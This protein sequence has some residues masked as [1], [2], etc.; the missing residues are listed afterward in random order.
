MRRNKNV[1]SAQCEV[2]WRSLRNCCSVSPARLICERR[3]NG[4][5][6]RCKGI[7]RRGKPVFLSVTWL[8]SGV[9][10]A[11]PARTN[12]RP[13]CA[14]KSR[15][16]VSH[17]DLNL[18]GEHFGKRSDFFLARSLEVG[19][20]SLA[21]ILQCRFDRLALRHAT[22]ELRHIRDVAMVFRVEDQVNK[23]PPGLSH[24]RI[25]EPRGRHE[26]IFVTS[27]NAHPRSRLRRGTGGSQRSL[28]AN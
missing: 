24:A 13:P 10:A 22:G 19:D 16:G 18:A 2:S 27:W 28:A 15:P 17:A 4:E 1:A 7:T 5:T 23:K 11:K 8:T 21:H 20:D 3:R 12:A 14:R 6:S 9:A 25:L 26:A